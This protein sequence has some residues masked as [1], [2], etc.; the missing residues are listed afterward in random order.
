MSE[1]IKVARCIYCDKACKLVKDGNKHHIDCPN[2]GIKELT[3]LGLA[4]ME[5]REK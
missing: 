4:R 5:A 2:C 1:I 3:K